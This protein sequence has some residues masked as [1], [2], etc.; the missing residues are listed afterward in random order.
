V[1]LAFPAECTT[2]DEVRTAMVAM[3]AE[4]RAAF[5]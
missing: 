3:V 1:R 5:A 2:G 4:A